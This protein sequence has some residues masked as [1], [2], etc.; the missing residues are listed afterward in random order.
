[1]VLVIYSRCLAVRIVKNMNWPFVD[2]FVVLLL[3]YPLIVVIVV[4]VIIV[5]IVIVVIIVII[6]IIFLHQHAVACYILWVKDRHNGNLMIDIKVSIN[7]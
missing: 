1:M 4:I 3:I 2:L 6:V 7:H 5:I